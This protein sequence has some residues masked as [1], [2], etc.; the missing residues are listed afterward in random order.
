[1]RELLLVITRKYFTQHS[2]VMCVVGL[3]S[4]QIIVGSFNDFIRLF[5]TTEGPAG[6]LQ[7]WEEEEEQSV[8]RLAWPPSRDI[9]TPS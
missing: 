7:H 6:Q 4:P 8:L 5:N 2:V 9:L 3:V 1:M